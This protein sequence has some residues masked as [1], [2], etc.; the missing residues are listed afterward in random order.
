MIGI[1]SL[2]LLNIVL[3]SRTVYDYKLLDFR[4]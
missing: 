2:V 1:G 4:F 3:G